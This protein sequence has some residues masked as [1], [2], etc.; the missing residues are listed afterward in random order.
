MRPFLE[1]GDR[2]FVG[3]AHGG[4]GFRR[5]CAH[6]CALLRRRGAHESHV[7]LSFCALLSSYARHRGFYRG[8]RRRA[9]AVR[10]RPPEVR[11]GG[12]HARGGSRAY[13]SGGVVRGG[14]LSGVRDD[15][16]RGGG[17]RLEGVSLCRSADSMRG[18]GD[19]GATARRRGGAR[20]VV[21]AYA[22]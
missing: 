16:A 13:R 11:V 9:S 21:P 14:G 22:L 5:L 15:C 10:G 17:Q 19:H 1:R 18:G 2:S 12:L 8:S 7:L 4:G 3:G 20:A 6:A